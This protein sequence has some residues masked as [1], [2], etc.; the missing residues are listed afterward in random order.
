MTTPATTGRLTAEQAAQ[1]R[2]EGYL[3]YDQ[4]VFEQTKFKRLADHFEQLLDDWTQTSG[5]S[6]ESMD[7]PH[8]RDPSLFEWLFD[9]QVLDI[10]ES[11]IGPDIALF[12][13]HFICK[14]PG[15][16]KR[17]PWHED[18]AYWGKRLDPMNVVTVW[19]A[20]DPASRAN[21]CMQVIPGTHDNG[22]SDYADVPDPDKQVFGREILADQIDE[23]KAVDIILEPNHCSLHHAKMI[24]GSA[25]NT[26]TQRRCG[27][28][29][30]Y[31]PTT[32]KHLGEDDLDFQIYLARGKDHAGNTY[33][34]PSKAL[35]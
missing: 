31:I 15:A 9:D 2:D 34:D 3:I 13:S 27:Y 21:G 11:V 35:K 8:F 17:V 14:P 29:M 5:R 26:G 16:G 20:I 12:S 25:A 19:L 23:S 24:H 6:P 22:Y 4:P 32:V 7:T 18:S 10:V 28:T 30:R 1:Y 33:G